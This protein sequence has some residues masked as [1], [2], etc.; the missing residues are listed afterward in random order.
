MFGDNNACRDKECAI[1]GKTVAKIIYRQY[2][3]ILNL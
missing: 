2:L 1:T 3:K